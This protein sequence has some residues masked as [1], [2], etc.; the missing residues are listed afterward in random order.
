VK[1]HA[2]IWK[3]QA[4]KSKSTFVS[5]GGEKDLDLTATERVDGGKPS[6]AVN[7]TAEGVALRAPVTH[8]QHQWELN[9]S[10]SNDS[11]FFDSSEL[12]SSNNNNNN[13][14][15][16]T[17]RKFFLDGSGCFKPIVECELSGSGGEVNKSEQI[18]MKEIRFV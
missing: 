16:M 14:S 7:R 18:L 2:L 8:Q 13:I 17:A 4:L 12:R 1:K 5:G 15:R 10:E 3:S 6:G 9:S 11:A